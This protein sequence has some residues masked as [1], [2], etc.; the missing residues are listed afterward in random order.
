M[1]AWRVKI[2]YDFVNAFQAQCSLSCKFRR[3]RRDSATTEYF[4]RIIIIIIIIIINT[5]V[6]M[7]VCTLKED[8]CMKSI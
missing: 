1:Q 3:L 4:N 8:Q 6:E 7:L 2:T 5:T